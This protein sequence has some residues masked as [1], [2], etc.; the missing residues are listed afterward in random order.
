MPRIARPGATC[1]MLAIAP[2]ATLAWR[3]T[4]L[5]TPVPSLMREVSRAK[6]AMVTYGSR[7]CVGGESGIQRALKPESSS[8]RAVATL[9]S[10]SSRLGMIKTSRPIMLF[11]ERA[12]EVGLAQIVDEARV[13]IIPGIGR[14]ELGLAVLR[15]HVED[16][17]DRLRARPGIFLVEADHLVFVAALERLAV[18]DRVEPQ[19]RRDRGDGELFPRLHR[20]H[21]LDEGLEEAGDRVAVARDVGAAHDD[22]LVRVENPQLRHL[23]KLPESQLPRH[24]GERRPADGP[25]D[26]TRLQRGQ[27]RRLPADLA[28]GGVLLRIG[29]R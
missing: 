3:V 16:E 28:E 24:A 1:S 17:L 25:V 15:H 22:A 29:P 18:L 21:A 2:A 9:A 6:S 20:V 26:A 10:Q 19:V 13:D 23:E 14:L 5:V 12:D 27:A 4:G 11:I 8:R 7:Q